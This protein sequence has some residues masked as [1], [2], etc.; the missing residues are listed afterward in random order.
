ML[1][2]VLVSV[3]AHWMIP[4][5]LAWGVALNEQEEALKQV[6]KGTGREGEEDALKESKKKQNP[7]F[8]HCKV[9]RLVGDLI[10]LRSRGW[11]VGVDPDG[12]NTWRGTT[13]TLITVALTLA[14][15]RRVI[16]E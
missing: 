11:C 4:S 9:G 6:L 14:T 1:T 15:V 16:D 3:L 13:G 12:R 7:L 8:W 5:L 10:A 2:F